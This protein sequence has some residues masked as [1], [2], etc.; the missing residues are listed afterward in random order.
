MHDRQ[1][2]ATAFREA[3]VKRLK[4]RFDLVGWNADTLVLHGQHHAA[5]L[6]P[7]A[8]LDLDVTLQRI[9]DARRL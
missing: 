8:D 9:I 3:A 6:P 1:T 7:A 5:A 2:E 4:E